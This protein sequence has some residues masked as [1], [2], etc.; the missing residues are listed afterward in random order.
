MEVTIKIFVKF[1]EVFSIVSLAGSKNVFV[2]SRKTCLPSL[3]CNR[4]SFAW[5]CY[6]TN[7][8]KFSEYSLFLIEY[9]I[10]VQQKRFVSGVH[11][12]YVFLL[13]IHTEYLPWSLLLDVSIQ[14]LVLF[15]FPRIFTYLF[16][17]IITHIISINV[18]VDVFNIF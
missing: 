1:S 15:F 2:F 4:T 6:E 12:L 13:P 7:T 3:S 9:Y 8:F 11:S 14:K 10:Y 17:F 18:S 16:K 5:F